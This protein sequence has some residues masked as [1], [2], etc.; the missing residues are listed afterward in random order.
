MAI[1]KTDFLEFSRCP[2]YVAL[3]R[4]NQDRLDADVSYEDY[5]QREYQLALEELLASMFEEDENGE[6]IDHINVTNRQLEAMM[7]Y[8]KRVEEE[9]GKLI[10][11]MFPGKTVYALETKN[12]ESFDCSY[13]GL[14]FLCY[15]DIYNECQD[16][17]NIIEVKATTS[18]KYVNL[19]GG[20]PK[21]EKYS[22][23]HKQNNIYALK[24]YIKDYPLEE[25]MP[26][27][28]YEKQKAKLLDRFKIG[29]Y[30][31]DLAVQRFI[32]EQEYI[33]SKNEEK[34]K[35]INYYL[36]VLNADYVFDGTY[37]N[38][39]AVYKMDENENE[40]ITLFDMNELTKDLQNKV[41]KDVDF[42]YEALKNS[43][44]APCPLGDYCNYKK[45]TCCK[46]FQPICG[47]MIPKK[48]SSL[49]YMHNGHGF[50]DENGEKHKGLQL[51]NEGYLDLLDI[52]EHW[53]INE[54][55][56]IQRNCYQ[57]NKVYINKE[58]I[59]KGLEQLEYPI[60]HLDFETFPCPVP[61]FKGESPFTQS[62]FE[63]SLHIELSV[64]V[65]D[66]EKDNI[67]FLAKSTEDEREE[68]IKTLLA[69]INPDKGTLFAQNV[70]FEKSR[71]KELA[72]C[73]PKYQEPLMKLY[74][75]GFDLLW[76]I[77][78]NQKMYE[79]LGVENSKIVNYYH[80][81]L[82][83]SYSIKKTLPIFST[84]TYENLEVKNGTEAIIEYA[85]YNKM[86]KEELALKQEALRIYCRQDTWAMVEI[87][88]SLRILSTER[89]KMPANVV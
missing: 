36:A 85:N 13:R 25:E 22:I 39:K 28:I 24:E 26:W 55:H 87:L 57:E 2:R 32:I 74:E 30:I 72:K 54:N 76:L 68:L 52:P 47:N 42:I 69:N 12:Q 73:F 21:Q 80:K 48:N 89:K 43:N 7:D 60:Y 51:I 50:K 59:Q 65:C 66:L 53:I 1:T 56:K 84:L 82:S 46:Y 29:S 35:D 19:Q 75:R 3:E 49:T 41:K 14:K 16:K 17:V 4:M 45:Q 77:N 37:E 58:K 70:A 27:N 15:V 78:N 9:A 33:T 71:I 86:S 31:Y 63:F 38:Q 18:K 67:I 83:G 61:R 8:Y 11:R 44:A 6:I 10:E 34:L 88:K 62:P 81:N 64:G 5:K 20:Y 23:F 79:E 40:L